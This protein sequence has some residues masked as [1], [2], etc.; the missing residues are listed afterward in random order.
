MQQMKD[1]AVQPG[2]LADWLQQPHPNAKYT[3]HLELTA[4]FLCFLLRDLSRG[5][6]PSVHISDFEHGNNAPSTVRS[7]YVAVFMRVPN[8]HTCAQ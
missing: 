6:W 1:G 4:N 2:D 3:H 7:S 5:T 8:Q